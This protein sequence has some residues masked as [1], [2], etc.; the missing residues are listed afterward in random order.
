MAGITSAISLCV[1]FNRANGFS[2][3]SL[4][5]R[6]NKYRGMSASVRR[7]VEGPAK[8]QQNFSETK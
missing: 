4:L 8:P 7:Q 5:N 6:R 3:N 2:V 1:A